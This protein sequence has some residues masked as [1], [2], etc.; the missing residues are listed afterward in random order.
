MYLV[1][2]IFAVLIA[3]MSAITMWAQSPGGCATTPLADAFVQSGFELS[4]TSSDL[5][6]TGNRAAAPTSGVQKS[7]EV[8]G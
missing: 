6:V 3:I 4:D 2:V 5:S 8:A 1:K 7:S